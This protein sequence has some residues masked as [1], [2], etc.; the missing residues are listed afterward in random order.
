MVNSE[1]GKGST[2]IF[3]AIF[4]QPY[5]INQK[6]AASRDA[7]RGVKALVVDSNETSRD[8][9]CLHLETLF[10]QVMSVSTGEQA[11]QMLENASDEDP[12]RLVLMDWNLPK[13]DGISVARHIKNN[14][15]IACIPHIIIVTS[16]SREDIVAASKRS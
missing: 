1:I 14:L 7:F 13:M 5:E 6:R 3:T 2:F 4:G 15:K 9:L 11:I 16:H 10:F 12:Y 8:A